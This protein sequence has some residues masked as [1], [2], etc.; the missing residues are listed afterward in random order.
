MVNNKQI[1][2]FVTEVNMHSD[3]SLHSKKFLL[4]SIYKS[5]VLYSMPLPP[6]TN[7]VPRFT[8]NTLLHSQ[9]VYN[10]LFS[11]IQYCTTKNKHVIQICTE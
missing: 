1:I 7:T 3:K 9:T 10:N 8:P 6:N 5:T 11:Y 4:Y 2:V